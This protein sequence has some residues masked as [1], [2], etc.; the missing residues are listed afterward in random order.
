MYNF[1]YAP[2]IFWFMHRAILKGLNIKD[3]RKCKISL[4][5]HASDI[6]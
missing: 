2:T 4:M 1:D 5:Y 6:D 3:K